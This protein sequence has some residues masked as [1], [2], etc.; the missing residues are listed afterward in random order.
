MTIGEI[1]TRKVIIAPRN[2]SVFQAAKLMRQHHSGDIVVT[3]E[4]DGRRTPVG[5]V[6]DR[7]LVLEIMA[8]GIDPAGLSVAEVMSDS[9]VTVAERD[10]VFET[11]ASMRSA[12][13]RRTPVVD[14]AGALIGI[15]SMDD[16]LE[17]MAEEMGN[18]ANV[19]R[20]ERLHEIEARK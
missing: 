4:T 10:G 11:I 1:C 3:D 7:D 2:T 15:V 16:V 20:Q 17:L 9:P 13:V 6:T 5:I 8:Q 14:S 19:V 12:G 18:L